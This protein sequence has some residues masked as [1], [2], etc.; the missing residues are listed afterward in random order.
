M[1]IQ[2]GRLGQFIL[3][4]GLIVFAVFLVSDQTA[5]PQFGLCLVGVLTMVL[6]IWLIWR[7]HKPPATEISR[8][9][10]YHKYQQKRREDREKKRAKR[11]G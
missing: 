9:R 7:D 6:G 4:I 11:G 10:S 5:S 3:V 1:S 8:F 2:R